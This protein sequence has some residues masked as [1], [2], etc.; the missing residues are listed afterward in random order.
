MSREIGVA[1]VGTGFVASMHLTALAR[2]PGVRVVGVVDVDPGRGQAAARGAGTRWTSSLDELLA[3]PDVDGCIVCTP[4]D[5][6]AAIGQSIAAAGKHL[7][8]EKPLTTDVAAA[9]SLVSAFSARGLVLMA[10]HTHRFADYGRIVKHTIDAGEIGRPVFIRLAILGG[11]IWPDWRAWVLDPKRSGGHVF[12]NGVHVLDL[13]TWWAGDQPVSVYAQG[14]KET[15]GDL[16]IYDYLSLLV[17]Y[18]SGC[19]AVCEIS[20]GNRPRTFGYRDVFV[21]GTTGSLSMPWDAEQGIAFLEGGTSLLP[22]DGQVG[23]DRE[24]A[25]WISAIRGETLPA[26]TGEDGRLSVAMAAAGEASLR[27]GECVTLESVGY[28]LPNPVASEGVS[29]AL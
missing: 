17:R 27:T 22:G 8:M 16:A 12:H 2:L 14:R 21:Q 1:V 23:F 25:A 9:D 28:T 24:V 10:A 18:R 29:R 11:W 7:L 4:N 19:T 20:R 6:H 13:A 5:T 15:S 3:W 26:V